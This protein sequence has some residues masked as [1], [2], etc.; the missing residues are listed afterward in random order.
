M[1][2][3]KGAGG[4][5]PQKPV[6]AAQPADAMQ[7]T[8]APSD[9]SEKFK[10]SM[11][12][13]APKKEAK[14]GEGGVLKDKVKHHKAIVKKLLVDGEGKKGELTMQIGGKGQPQPKK[15][16]KGEMQA[17]IKEGAIPK[18]GKPLPKQ[19]KEPAS[20]DIKEAVSQPA[21]QQVQAQQPTT[22]PLGQQVAPAEGAQQ[23]TLSPAKAEMAELASSML[24]KMHATDAKL[25]AG[26]EVRMTFGDTNPNLKGVEVTVKKDGNNLTVQFNANTSEATNYIAQNK[27]GLMSNLKSDI[28]DVQDINIDIQQEGADSGEQQEG[29]SREQYVGED[30]PEEENE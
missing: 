21:Q 11:E 18:E 23:A 5:V 14:K 4:Q 6:D 16:L 13:Q 26:K 29:R 2:D 27:E 7:Q 25:N 15:G 1:A 10:K 30:I 20:K 19:T 8:Q 17:Q 22:G 9:V 24:E 28:K 12:Q 3:I